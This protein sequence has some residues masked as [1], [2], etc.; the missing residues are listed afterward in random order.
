[1]YVRMQ[2]IH[3]RRL[4]ITK[5]VMHIYNTGFLWSN[6]TK[7]YQVLYTYRHPL[8]VALS[9]HKREFEQFKVRRGLKLWYKHFRFHTFKSIVR[10]VLSWKSFLDNILYAHHIYFYLMWRYIKLHIQAFIKNKLFCWCIGRYVYNRRAVLQSQDLCRVRTSHHAIIVQPQKVIN[11]LPCIVSVSKHRLRYCLCITAC[12]GAGPHLHWFES[13]WSACTTPAVRRGHIR[14]YRYQGAS[15]K[16]EFMHT[17][18][19]TLSS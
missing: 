14:F 12:I 11:N 17:Y 10:S 5:I 15:C 2:S 4:L 1:M 6:L 19:H 13:L 7:N 3:S 18:I 16:S 9:M 8:D